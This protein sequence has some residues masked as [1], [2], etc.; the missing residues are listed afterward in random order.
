MSGDM[1]LNVPDDGMRITRIPLPD[2]LIR[3]ESMK[4]AVQSGHGARSLETM[5]GRIEAYVRYGRQKDEQGYITFAP[6]CFMDGD[7]NVISF[8]G[9]NFFRACDNFVRR[10]E[11]GGSSHCVKRAG[12]PSKDCEDWD[13]NIRS[14]EEGDIS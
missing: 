11:D 8:K 10:R 2:D 3:L 14:L 5:A 7:G 6:E 4:L 12:H 9:E 1:F 13:G